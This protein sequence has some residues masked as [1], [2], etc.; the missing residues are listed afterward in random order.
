[1]CHRT[2]LA[3]YNRPTEVMRTAAPILLTSALITL[4]LATSVSS[5][6][7]EATLTLDPSSGPCNGTTTATGTGFA[8]NSFVELSLGTTAGDAVEGTLAIAPTDGT[9]SFA[10]E[11]PFGTLGCDLLARTLRAFEPDHFTVYA[12]HNYDPNATSIFAR[13]DY[14][15]TTTALPPTGGGPGDE[16]G[17][18]LIP[19]VLL[20]MVGCVVCAAGLL[21]RRA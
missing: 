10:V 7:A 20:V 1:M 21:G 6:S 11:F 9:G 13:T 19:F 16:H 3:S 17:A 12:N 15:L 4:A 18:A 2:C 14:G 5:V 8:P